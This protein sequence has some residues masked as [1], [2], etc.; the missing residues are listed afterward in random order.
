[1]AETTMTDTTYEKKEVPMTDEPKAADS[2]AKE[3]ALN[4]SLDQLSYI[5][6]YCGKVNAISSP[7]CVRCGKRR[8]RSEYVNAMNKLKNAESVKAQYIEEQAKLAVDRREAA[9]QQLV[10]LVESRVADEKAQ[11]VAQE[12]IKL[13]QER[14]EIKRTTARDAVLRIIAAERAAEE[15]VKVAEARA[16]EAIAGRSRETEERIA[17]EREKVLYAAAKRVVSERAGIENAA[18]ERIAA[19]RKNTEKKAQE[20][21]DFAVDEAEK[22]AARRAVL[23]IVAGEQAAEDRARIERDAISRAAMDRVAEEKEIAEIN[24]YSKYKIEKEAIERAVDERIKAER[25]MLYG[26][27][28]AATAPYGQAG[29]AVQPLTIVPY[30]NSRQPLYQYAPSKTIYKFVPDEQPEQQRPGRKAVP[31]R[32]PSSAPVKEKKEK[33]AKKGYGAVRALSVIALLLAAVVLVGSLVDVAALRYVADYKN[34]DVVT[35]LFVQN[36]YSAFIADKGIVGML[37]P[38]G[39]IVACVGALA[40]VICAIVGLI[41][42]K[43]KAIFPILAAVGTVGAIVAVVGL[44][45]GN[46]IAVAEI[47]SLIGLIV[48]VAASV[49]ALVFAAITTAITAKKKKQEEAFLG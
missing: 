44:I 10:R 45:V 17:S 3:M 23:K 15:K 9:E 41:T 18:E 1:M 20:T 25:E 42:G 46:V 26:R 24:A 30:V 14:E 21:I 38:I 37:A 13:E 39:I 12:A 29:G 48:L 43:A 7:N 36:D 49:L 4:V 2:A 31:A 16:E 28:G 35:A 19:E 6:G 11:I 27:R 8:P 40:S 22:N 32:M 34:F 33:K 5:C 47:A